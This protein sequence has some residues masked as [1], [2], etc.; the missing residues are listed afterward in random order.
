MYD[1]PPESDWFPVRITASFLDG[2]GK[3]AYTFQE[4]WLDGGAAIADKIG[5]RVNTSNDPAYAIDGST[6]SPTA[7]GSNV[8]GLARRGPGAA[9]QK[10][11]L[12][13]GGGGNTLNPGDIAP[14]EFS[15]SIAAGQ[16]WQPVPII[17]GNLSLF[18]DQPLGMFSF[19]VLLRLLSGT[20]GN[21]SVGVAIGRCD[22]TGLISSLQSPFVVCNP[23]PI[24]LFDIGRDV[25]MHYNQPLNLTNINGFFPDFPKE[26]D[27]LA[28]PVVGGNGLSL[29][30]A[31]SLDP[32]VYS[33]AAVGALASPSY[34]SASS[35]TTGISTI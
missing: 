11:E 29:T 10:W 22:A 8:Q 6:F 28:F 23:I 13:G 15:G 7:A 21:V 2:G 31:P 27:L 26:G 30:P 4:V 25:L 20:D 17:G 34:I 18:I 14:F 35:R 12:K 16:L 24:H 5:G 33:I 1:V 9:G 19:Y 32:S 3:T